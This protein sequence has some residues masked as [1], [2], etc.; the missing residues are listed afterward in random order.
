HKVLREQLSQTTHILSSG[1]LQQSQ[2][3]GTKFF[4][5][6]VDVAH[7]GLT[8]E[9]NGRPR[10]PLRTGPRTQCQGAHGA[11]TLLHGD[12]D[13]FQWTHGSVSSVSSLVVN[14]R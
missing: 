1:W 8:I 3:K 6:V 10:T 11:A 12:L 14:G 7:G 5:D 9:L 13:P 4:L 2:L